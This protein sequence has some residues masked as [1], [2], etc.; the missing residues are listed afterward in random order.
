MCRLITSVVLGIVVSLPTLGRAA[1]P[2]KPGTYE[3]CIVSSAAAETVYGLIKVTAK[4]DDWD[5]EV[6]AAR[7]QSDLTV[8]TVSLDGDT[9]RIAMR[10][11]SGPMSFEGHIRGGAGPV[12]GTL[13]M[14]DRVYAA[15]LTLSLKT[16]LATTDLSHRLPVPDPMRQA[17]ALNAKAPLLRTQARRAEDEAEKAELL[18]K[19][20]EA[21]AH[22]QAEV[23]A[24]Y[25]AVI[26]NFGDSPAAGDAALN[27]IKIAGKTKAESAEVGR[28][29]DIVRKRAAYFGPRSEAE[30][31]AQLAQL[32]VS[33]DGFAALALDQAKLAD[34]GLTAKDSPE[35]RER[36][37]SFLETAQRRAGQPTDADTTGSR[38]AKMRAELDSAYLAKVPPF[39]PET[40]AGRKAQSDRA[41]VMELFTGAECPPCVAADVAFDVLEKTYKPAELILIQYHVHIPGPDPLT[42]PASE[43]RQKYYDVSSTPSTLFN[44]K[45]EARGGGA[46]TRAKAKYTEFRK[47]VDAALEDPARAALS[48]HADLKGDALTVRATLSNL[49]DAGADKRLR[50]VLVEDTVRF[51]GGNKL[52]FHHAVARAL[53]GGPDGLALTQKDNAYSATLNLNDLRQDLTKYLDEY[54]LEK[55]PFP[56]PDR[57]MAFQHLKVIALIQDDKTHEILQAA[58]T[59]VAGERAAN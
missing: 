28:W 57:P 31:A 52:R 3:L 1:T 50:F 51:A 12:V 26:A 30:M 18:K 2:P 43:R 5:G 53:P 25:R 9:L 54:A 33:T 21:D 13:D 24:L 20:Q 11:P 58:V 46:I 55:R 17:L 27:L 49:P 48:V 16:E 23:P 14:N 32:L 45:P 37:L 39:K 42:N 56:R 29:V 40:Y 7:P 34:A 4:D 6:I 10:G 38:L 59:D 36:V 19:A 8:R 15:K 41:V 47:I 44:G 35:K 22:A